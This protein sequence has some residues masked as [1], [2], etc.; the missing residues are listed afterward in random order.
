M[1]SMNPEDPPPPP[2]PPPI[3]DST[4]RVDFIFATARIH[5]NIIRYGMLP[6][7]SI[8]YIDHC[9]LYIDIDVEPQFGQDS[10]RF[11]P[12]VHRKLQCRNPTI[13]SRYKECLKKKLAHHTILERT[14]ALMAVI[15]GSWTK[16]H[17]TAANTIASNIGDSQEFLESK[18]KKG[19]SRILDWSSELSH[20]GKIVSY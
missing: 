6:K 9:A 10:N 13:V 11:V 8:F 17:T 2:P 14:D 15:I 20:A 4:R 16:N 19:K 12:Q 5:K 3:C 7:A 18:C 1:V